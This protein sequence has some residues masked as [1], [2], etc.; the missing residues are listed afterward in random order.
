MFYPFGG[1]DTGGVIP[2]RVITSPD[3]ANEANFTT[4]K[5]EANEGKQDI[6]K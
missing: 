3:A 5:K 4:K 1:L 2:I 6:Q